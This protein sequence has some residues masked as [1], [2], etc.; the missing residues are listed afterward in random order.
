MEEVVLAHGCVEQVSR[1]NARWILVVILGPRRGNGNILGTVTRRGAQIRAERRADGSCGRRQHAAAE[2]PC[3][4][5]LIGRYSGHVDEVIG[6]TTGW[7]VCTRLAAETRHGTRDK[8]AIVAPVE[9]KPRPGLPRLIL[10]VRG[11]VEVF[12]VVDAK[13]RRSPRRGANAADLRSKET[14]RH[15]GHHYKR[16]QAMEIRNRGADGVAGNLRTIPLDGIRDRSV[17]Q[18]AE[19]VGVV[20]VL[21]DVFGVDDEVLAECLPQS[22]VK[23]IA[24][25]RT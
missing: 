23:F 3:L 11:L 14:R 16:R 21:P 4:E 10:D 22:R 1:R 19:V 20:R 25:S 13:H 8:A 24:K 6:A 2:Q 7:A 18:H 17:A 12:I 5:L 15:A 9:A